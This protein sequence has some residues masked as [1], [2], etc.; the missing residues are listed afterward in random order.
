MNKELELI[1]CR[2]WAFWHAV[3]LVA[4][5]VWERISHLWQD[6]AM[7]TKYPHFVEEAMR[8]TFSTLN[9]RQRRLFA[10]TEAL[11]LGHGGIAYV[12]QLLDCHRR[13]IERGLIE[14]RHPGRPLPPERARKKGAADEGA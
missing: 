2:N 14:L 8:H 6:A 4:F 11:K 3:W 9:E 1:N 5:A 10:A 7:L 12:A 13:T